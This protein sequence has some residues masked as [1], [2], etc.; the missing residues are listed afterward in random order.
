MRRSEIDPN[1]LSLNVV[2]D[3]AKPTNGWQDKTEADYDRK[4]KEA[5]EYAADLQK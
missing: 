1:Q 3:Y 2:M 4:M 5:D